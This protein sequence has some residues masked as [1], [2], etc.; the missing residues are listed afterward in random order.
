MNTD[1]DAYVHIDE[2]WYLVMIAAN[3]GLRYLAENNEPITD[4]RKAKRYLSYETA[5]TAA[6]NAIETLSCPAM[7]K[8]LT[9]TYNV[10]NVHDGDERRNPENTK[11][12]PEA[13]ADILRR[14]VLDTGAISAVETETLYKA[15]PSFPFSKR[16]KLLACLWDVDC[17]ARASKV[18][19]AETIK[20][21]PGAAAS[22]EILRKAARC[23]P[24]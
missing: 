1:T 15:W 17:A 5:K 18:S 21:N 2:T 10:D 14:I 6:A 24:D 22:I 3:S 23:T 16:S 12:V 19:L 4:P 11:A 7:A 13:Y 9:I 8:R 20:T